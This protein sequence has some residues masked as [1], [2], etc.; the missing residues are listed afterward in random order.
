MCGKFTQMFGWSDVVRLSD[1]IGRPADDRVETATPMRFANVITL[2]ADGKRVS[3]RMRWGLITPSATDPNKA[4]LHI[5]ARCETIERLP[6]FAD[7]FANRRGILLTSTFNEGEEIT[8]TKTQQY[9]LTPLDGQ[10]VAIAVIWEYWASLEGAELLTFA[11]VT[12]P[13][14]ELIA[15]ITDRMPAV[16]PEADWPRWLGEEPASID[17]LKAMLR[18]S[19]RAFDMKKAEKKP[20]PPPKPKKPREP[21]PQPDLF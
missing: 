16:L 17:E 12:T 9:V 1:L 3:R 10:P 19:D 11:M 18:T 14:N 21:D 2:D 4:K 5:H 6:T 8:P 20:P 13:P 15:T 7:A